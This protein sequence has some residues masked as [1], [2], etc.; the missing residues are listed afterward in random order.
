MDNEKKKHGFLCW[1]GMILLW[2]FLFPAMLLVFL[3]KSKKLPVFVKIPLI[4][5]H[6]VLWSTVFLAIALWDPE[7]P[8]IEAHEVTANYNTPIKLESLASI[9]DNKDEAPALAIT[10]CDPK[11]GTISKD[12]KTVTFSKVGKFTVRVEG[13][14]TAANPASAEVP[15]TITDGTPPVIEANKTQFPVLEA[16]QITEIGKVKDEIDEAPTFSITKCEGKAEVAE[17]GQSVTFKEPG[18][19]TVGLK[20]VDASANECSK[21]VKV[22]V[23]NTIA[24]EITLSEKEISIADTDAN[25]DFAGYAKAKSSVYGDLTKDIEIDPSAVKYGTPGKYTVKYTVKDKD[26]NTD[27]E[28]LTVI[29]K[30]TTAPELQGVASEFTLTQGD[31]AP[32][33][34]NGLSASDSV[35]GDMTSKVAVDDSGVDYGTPGTYIVLFS[36]IDAAG[37]V[38]R[39][40]ASVTVNEKPVE[41]PVEQQVTRSVVNEEPKQEAAAQSGQETGS[42]AVTRQVQE[43]E[44][45]ITYV[46]NTNTRK[47][48]YPRCGS[49]STI[50]DKNRQDVTWSRDEVIARGYDP[51]QRCNP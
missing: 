2:I 26:G 31:A 34:L 10:Y 43:P 48:H 41:Q 36:V 14:D 25:I 18:E 15:V 9:T 19:Y 45:E 5:I 49:V 8:V 44:P 21:E 4:L 35:D 28:A 29:I 33:Y 27:S 51:C 37:N 22:E 3:V 32:D 23:R 12:G 47:F 46:L 38:T 24:P 40:E 1:I 50:K 11:A 6:M 42:G 20:A 7:P 16:V 39:Q 30:D 17:D 13:S